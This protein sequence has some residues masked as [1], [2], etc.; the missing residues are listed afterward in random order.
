MRHL[1][2]LPSISAMTEREALIGKVIDMEYLPGGTKGRMGR[3]FRLREDIVP[4][5]ATLGI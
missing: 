1:R 2:L 4:C 3:I 5:G